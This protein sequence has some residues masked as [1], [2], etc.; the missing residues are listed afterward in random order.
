MDEYLKS[1]RNTFK[2]LKN[3][4]V[5]F[6]IGNESCDLDS[7]VCAI[8]YA[9]WLNINKGLDDIVFPLLNVSKV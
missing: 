4:N 9:Y 1:L 2:D 6:V 8:V 3:K 7:A 5:T